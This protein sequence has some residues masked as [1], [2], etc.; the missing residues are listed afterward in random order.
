M[1]NCKLLALDFDGV[2][3]DSATET[4]LSAWRCAR[5]LWP[6]VFPGEAPAP[7]LIQAFRTRRPYL[8]TGFQSVIILKLIAEG[9]PESEFAEHLGDHTERMLAELGIDRAEII[10]RFGETRDNWIAEDC[11]SWLDS[12]TFFPGAIA[13]LR[14]AMAC[15]KVY[16]LT[17]RQERFT[18]LLLRGQGVEFPDADIWGLDRKEKKEQ[19]LLRFRQ[20]F[21]GEIYF[22][23]DRLKTL[24]RT[25]ATPGLESVRLLY[26]NW[27]YGTPKEIAEAAHTPGVTSI[28]YSD[29]LNLLQNP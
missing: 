20:E 9:Q 19:T 14:Q 2:L 21:D 10:R 22:V 15:H 25:V 13:A 4:G 11:Q 6:S 24:T 7:G 16:I 12:L 27:G 18:K 5:H 26:A 3:C 17:T 1:S 29:F 23:E 8:E 28:S